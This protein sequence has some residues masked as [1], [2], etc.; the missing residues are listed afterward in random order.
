MAPITFAWAWAGATFGGLEGVAGRPPA[1]PAERAL[2][3]AGLLATV[4]VVILLGRMAR[5]ALAVPPTK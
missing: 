4:G 5:R 1:G 2:Q 3:W